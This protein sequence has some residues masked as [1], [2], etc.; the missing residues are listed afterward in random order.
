MIAVLIARES[1]SF[2]LQQPNAV[3]IGRFLPTDSSAR[4]R[5]ALQGTSIAGRLARPIFPGY[6]ALWQC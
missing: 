3:Q 2:A 4:N 6:H 5:T 1:I